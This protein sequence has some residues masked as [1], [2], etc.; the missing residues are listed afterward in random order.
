VLE[1]RLINSNK[2][3]SLELNQNILL[4][5]NYRLCK[6]IEEKNKEIEI[7]KKEAILKIIKQRF[8]YKF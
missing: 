8:F 6:K 1:D 3:I 5:E 4:S 7:I 2:S